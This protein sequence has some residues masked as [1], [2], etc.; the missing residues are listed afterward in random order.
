MGRTNSII[1]DRKN[2]EKELDI[3]KND[4][5]TQV[6]DS[7]KLKYIRD[8]I[9]SKVEEKLEKS[10]SNVSITTRDTGRKQTIDQVNKF[11]NM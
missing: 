10:N 8:K 7:I 3:E 5:T 11:E 1:M 6:L 2:S 9:K 4:F